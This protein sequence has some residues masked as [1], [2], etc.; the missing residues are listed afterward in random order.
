MIC[1]CTIYFT[2]LKTCYAFGEFLLMI[3][4]VSIS[5]YFQ[6]IKF[7]CALLR[8][9]KTWLNFSMVD[10][11]WLFAICYIC[12][13]FGNYL[14][15][16]IM[17][18]IKII[19]SS[20]FC[21]WKCFSPQPS[22]RRP[23]IIIHFIWDQSS[24]PCPAGHYMTSVHAYGQ[25]MAPTDSQPNFCVK[26]CHLPNRSNSVRIFKVT[27]LQWHIVDSGLTVFDR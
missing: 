8:I 5:K 16:N 13:A 19:S 1:I 24:F 17:S 14:S 12:Y 26:G 20:N 10:F 25:Q 11:L 4:V 9:C 27:L 6:S 2:C 23:C 22:L 3:K 7:P 18:Y 21:H 15:M